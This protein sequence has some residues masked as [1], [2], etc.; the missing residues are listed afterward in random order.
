ML[1]AT[2]VR[3][4][5]PG[6]LRAEIHPTLP[7][8]T[9]ISVLDPKFLVR[10]LSKVGKNAEI[11]PAE[12]PKP[13]GEETCWEAAEIKS[14]EP[15]KEAK[16]GSGSEKPNPE[17][18]NST[19][20]TVNDM[21]SSAS[22]DSGSPDDRN[23]ETSDGAEATKSTNATI[24]A[25]LA[26]VNGIA[27]QKSAASQARVFCPISEPMSSY[28]AMNAYPSPAPYYYDMPAPPSAATFHDCYCSDD[29]YVGCR[30]M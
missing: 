1:H 24:V 21:N 30:I 27:N 6:V 12:I 15:S 14:G 25:T 26:Q 13:Q 22:I 28:C 5:S 19:S 11:L 3:M 7:K 9:V 20:S 4:C 23:R 2:D 18:E 17:K 16:E 10:K 8:L 29:N